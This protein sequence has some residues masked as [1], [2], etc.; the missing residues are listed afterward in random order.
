MPWPLSPLTTY[1]ANSVPTIKAFDLNAIQAAINSLFGGTLSVKSLRFD[2]TGGVAAAPPTGTGQVTGLV[3]GTAVPT[4]TFAMGTIGVGS[5]VG[6]W[7][8]ITGA[9]ALIR[10]YNVVTVSRTGGG[11]AAGDYTVVFSPTPADPAKACAWVA[12]I[13]NGTPAVADHV[14]TSSGAN[15]ALRLNVYDLGGT[16]TDRAV[17]C[18]FFTE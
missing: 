10:G 3:A 18:G 17:A 13:G 16:R 2:G 15:Q 9:G 1:V 14:P 5:I 4:T 6:G 7:A 12:I 11:A 8:L